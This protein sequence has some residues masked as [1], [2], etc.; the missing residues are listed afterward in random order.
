[1]K[2]K[3]EIINSISEMVVGRVEDGYDGMQATLKYGSRV[4]C[5]IAS[6]GMGWDHVSVSMKREAPS[7]DLMCMIKDMFFRD[8][9]VVLQYHP[10]KASYVNVHKHCLHLWR[11]Q[12]VEVPVPD[13]VMV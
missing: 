7:W 9:E 10:A 2:T 4:F 8:D 1:M 13:L 6:W 3:P 12:N 11:P 5:V